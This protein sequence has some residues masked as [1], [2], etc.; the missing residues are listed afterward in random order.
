MHPPTSTLNL[1]RRNHSCVVSKFAYSH[2]DGDGPCDGHITLTSTSS[3]GSF[4]LK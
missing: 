1:R 2:N 4:H 3:Y